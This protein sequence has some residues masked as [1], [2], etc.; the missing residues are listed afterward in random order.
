MRQDF[1]RAWGMCALGEART[2]Y[3]FSLIPEQPSRRE[4][5][6]WGK[7]K[8]ATARSARLRR[9][10]RFGRTTTEVAGVFFA[11]MAIPWGN[12]FSWVVGVLSREAYP[13]VV[14]LYKNDRAPLE[15]TRKSLPHDNAAGW[16]VSSPVVAHFSSKPLIVDLEQVLAARLKCDLD[17]ALTHRR[18]QLSKKSAT[19]KRSAEIGEQ[20]AQ[21]L[22]AL[23]SELRAEHSAVIERHGLCRERAPLHEVH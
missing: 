22:H 15:T 21:R 9:L 10:Y 6:Q 2:G 3:T 17:S 16:T 8:T 4:R 7:I 19:L 5:P 12:V 14:A 11:A 1:C 23:D 18:W 13:R 20:W